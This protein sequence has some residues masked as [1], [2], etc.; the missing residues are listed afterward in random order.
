MSA[1]DHPLA[2]AK[3][4]SLTTFRRDGRAVSTPVWVAPAVDGTDRL[5]VIT[6]DATG[7]TKRLGHTRR[8]E[9]R[10]CSV[11]GAVEEGAPTY[12]GEGVVVR[13]PEEVAQVRAAVVAKYGLPARMSDLV[14]KV[15]GLVGVRRNPRAGILLEVERTPVA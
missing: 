9:L 7:K 10:P 8:V 3:Y 6:V 11:R 2:S 14:E 13:S 1:A 4:V 5:A 15:T 12:R